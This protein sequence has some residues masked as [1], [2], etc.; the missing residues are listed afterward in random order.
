MPTGLAAALGALTLLLGACGGSGADSTGSPPPVAPPPPP[1]PPNA[2][3]QISGTPAP[4]VEVGATYSFTPA[5][6]DPDGDTLSFAILNRP[7]WASF[8]AGTGLLT[9]TPAAGDVGTARDIRITVSDGRD[10]ASLAD[11]SIEVLPRPLVS[12]TVRW[13]PPTTNADG[14][15][16]TDLSGFRVYYGTQTATYDDW[17]DVADA[18]ATSAVVDNLQPG[19]YYFAVT[20]LDPNGNESVPSDEVSSM[21]PP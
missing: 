19:L 8:D 1:P 4:S 16:L 12:V 10:A 21:V 11:F 18:A 3:P 6:T 20:A 2:P 13:D 7:G 15:P 9:G 14:S 5:A 17:I